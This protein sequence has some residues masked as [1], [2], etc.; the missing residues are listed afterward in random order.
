MRHLYVHV[1]AQNEA[2]RQ[3]YCEQCGFE[4]EAEESENTAR[5][6]NRPRRLL[7]HRVL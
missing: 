7:L 6:L 2:A 1:E 4:V 5:A 3:L